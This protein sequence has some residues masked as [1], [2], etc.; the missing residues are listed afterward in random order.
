VWVGAGQ[1]PPRVATHFGLHGEPNGWQTHAEYLRF[2]LIFAAVVPAFVLG[3]FS[4]IRVGDGALMNIP[5]KK[6]WLAPE[7]RAETI[8]FVQ[9]Q[10]AWFASLLIVFFAAI[11]HFIVMANAR[12]PARLP[13]NSPFWAA[14]ILIAVVALVVPVSFIRHFHR[15]PA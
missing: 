5:H 4:L 2:T 3:A 7:R 13:P 8:A 12:S 6:Y 10:G 11:H 15:K 9:R 1:L 14:G